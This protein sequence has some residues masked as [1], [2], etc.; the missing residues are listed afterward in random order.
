MRFFCIA[1]AAASCAFADGVG[2]AFPQENA[3]LPAVKRTY[4]I[5]AIPAADATQPLTIAGVTNDVYK[6]GAFIAMVPVEGGTN[7]ITLTWGTNTL[8]RTFRVAFP[9][10]PKPAATNTPPR[11]VR[12]DLGIPP[13]EE[14]S[15]ARPK[16]KRIEDLTV[17]IDPGHGGQ[18]TGALMPHGAGEKTVNLLQAQ[19]IEAEFAKYGIKTVMTRTTDD[20]FPALYARPRR[21]YAEKVDAF[22]SVHHNSTAADRDPREVRHTAA[23]ASTTNGLA[24][25]KALQQYVGPQ[26]TGVKNAGAQMRSYAVFRNPAV[27]SCLLE[28]DFINLPEGE[29]AALNDADRRSRIAHAVLIG[30]LD[31]LFAPDDGT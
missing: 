9:S 7:T 4:V 13:D 6:T 15:D 10:P 24:L 17:M 8:D 16:G 14:V 21:A 20:E 29:D 23:Y 3:L 11:D 28:I 18:D 25:A 22:I 27:A 12:K 31:W 5:G 30:F 1:L 19:A 26:V 2:I